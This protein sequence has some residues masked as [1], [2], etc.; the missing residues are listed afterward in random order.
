MGREFV[1][2]MGPIRQI[3][4]RLRSSKGGVFVLAGH[5][6]EPNIYFVNFLAARKKDTVVHRQ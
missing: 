6:S 4:F 1:S 5:V 2:R 3:R